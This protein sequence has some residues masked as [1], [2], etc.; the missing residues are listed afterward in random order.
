MIKFSFFLFLLFSPIFSVFSANTEQS[1]QIPETE[2][3]RISDTLPLET[4]L[5]E[6][7]LPRTSLKTLIT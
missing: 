4:P 1:N 7:T 2:Q 6:K 3:R 5:H